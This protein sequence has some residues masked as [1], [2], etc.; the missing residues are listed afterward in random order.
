MADDLD[1][2]AMLEAPYKKED[3]VKAQNGEAEHSEIKKKKKKRSRSRERDTHRDRDRDRGSDRRDRDRDRDADRS[4]NRGGGDRHG[5][6]RDSFRGG[7]RRS[8]SPRR[9]GGDHDRFRGRDSG[10]HGRSD[11]KSPG[12][13][14]KG[15][16]LPGSFKRRDGP[17]LTPEER[18][19]RTVFCMQL[20]GRCRERDL[21]EF[22]SSVGQ[23]R[24]V[25][26]IVDNK[27][28]RSKGIAYIEFVDP[29]SVPL[30][31]GLNGQKL[32]GVP[33]I[34]Q[35][36]QAEKNRAAQ[37]TTPGVAQRGNV[38]PM[39]LYVGSLHFNI[40]ED[41]L[42]GIFEP[43]GK[44]DHIRLMMDSETGRARGYGFVT[45]SKMVTAAYVPLLNYHNLFPDSMTSTQMMMR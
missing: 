41:M 17:E 6:G 22:F 43:F 7:R 31:M 30:A 39:K 11:S 16:N 23:V 38:G 13:G 3:D 12:R 9:R 28:R 27:T 25:R 33:I 15:D 40:T 19:Q 29:E 24:D 26:L 14:G 42:K 2:E 32:L 1:V 36:S 4:R 37:S 8:R 20:A 44:I 35:P 5:R 34:I 45:V 10:R 18:D 21:E